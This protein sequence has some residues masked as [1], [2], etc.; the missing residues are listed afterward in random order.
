MAHQNHYAEGSAHTSD[1]TPVVA[2]EWDP[3]DGAAYHVEMHAIARQSNGTGRAAFTQ[4][5]IISKDAG[6][7]TAAGVGAQEKVN[8][9]GA[10][11]WTLAASIS[12]NKVVVT[13]TGEAGKVIDCNVTVAG[14]QAGPF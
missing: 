7:V 5:A 1:A 2:L 8:N 4:T 11:A 12:G 13:F 3:Q 10:A 9:A 14:M 6:T